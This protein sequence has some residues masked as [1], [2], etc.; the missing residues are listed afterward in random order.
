M[1]QVHRL[2]SPGGAAVALAVSNFGLYIF[3]IVDV[4]INNQKNNLSINL[5][6]NL[7]SSLSSYLAGTQFIFCSLVFCISSISALRRALMS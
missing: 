2:A 3:L 5:S 4:S 6:S 7:L 1:P